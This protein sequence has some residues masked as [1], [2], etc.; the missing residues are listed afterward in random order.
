MEPPKE[1]I[2]RKSAYRAFAQRLIDLG[3]MRKT[4]E[5]PVLGY[6]QDVLGGL[7]GWSGLRYRKLLKDL[8]ESECNDSQ[9]LEMLINHY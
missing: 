5:G 4:T 8:I 3:G 2:Q 1:W 6:Q 7:K 9:S